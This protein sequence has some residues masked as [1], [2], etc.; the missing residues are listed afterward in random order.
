MGGPGPRSTPTIHDGDVY[1]FGAQGH[2][3]CLDG[4][5]GKPRW[6]VVDVVTD[7]GAKVVQWGMTSSPLV[8]G[9][10]VV[11]NAGIDPANNQHHAV[12]AYDRATGKKIWAVGEHAA[13]YS[14]PMLATFD[15]MAQIVLFDAGGV[16]GI[17]P[18]DGN[19][20]WR[21]P[22]TTFNDMNIIQPLILPGD[23]VFISSE[24]TNGCALVEIKK[25][26]ST[27]SARPVWTNRNLAARFAN[28]VYAAGHIYG[29]SNSRLCCLSAETG[30][31]LWRSDEEFGSGQLLVCGR[32]L[33]VQPER[34]GEVLAVAAEP[35]DY[36]ELWREQVFRGRRTWNTPSLAG[37]KLYVRNHEEMVCLELAK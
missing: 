18:A 25:S 1:S 33:L 16:A 12:A 22:W 21:H 20:L 23:R 8:V 15:G 9:K 35:A 11:V 5:T 37:G 2:L 34:T 32:V 27:W 29:L 6:P 31:R 19:E 10:L 3:V 36:R 30:K 13:G 26:G 4:T 14:S 7:N 28:P 17:D 24:L